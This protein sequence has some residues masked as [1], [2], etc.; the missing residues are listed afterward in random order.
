MGETACAPS[1]RLREHRA[2]LIVH[3]QRGISS[4]GAIRRQFHH[5][6][7]V[8]PTLYDILR[9]EAPTQYR[10]RVQ[11]PLHGISMAYTFD[12]DEPTR[13]DTQY[14]EL[15]G[16]RAIWQRGWK[17][18]T[19]H[20]KDS[21][22]DADRWE[23]Y[24]VDQDFAELNDL[25]SAQPD[26]LRKLIELWWSEAGKYNVLPLDDRDW[27]RAAERLKMNPTTRYEYMADMARI[28]RL[29]APDISDRAYTVTALFEAD[30]DAHGVIL[31]WGSLFGGFVIYLKDG[32][33]CYE[34][35][36]SESMKHAL[37]VDFPHR[38]GRRTIQLK[39]ERTSSQARRASLN[40]DGTLA[41]AIDIPRNWPTHGTTAGLTCGHDAGAPVSDAYERPFPFTGRHL[42]V[43]IE[44]ESGGAGS[45]GAAYRAVFKEQ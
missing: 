19:R 5:V 24:H 32:R 40:V 17:A 21:D 39:L 28:D 6:I 31:A 29:S 30:R 44:L 14:F 36:F 15:V 33:L 9:I 11:M 45:S 18:V 13:K 7:D 26:K 3:W 42:R 20:P 12:G 16:D 2:P 23:L 10:G 8:A 1:R 34:Y 35:V 41:G 27:E 22:F 4:H 37:D 25:A 38:T 43:T